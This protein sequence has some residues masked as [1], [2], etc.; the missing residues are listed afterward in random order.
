MNPTRR[1][2]IAILAAGT[3]T[4]LSGAL[5]GASPL[6]W[7]GSGLG[8]RASLTLVGLDPATERRVV[9]ACRDEISR[10]EAVFS[11]YRDDSALSHLN[12]EGHLAA[13]PHELVDVLTAT[14]RLHA[15]SNG[16]FDP[17]VQPLWQLLARTGG[18]P[19]PQAE[20]AAR[21]RIGWHRVRWSPDAID[22]GPGMALTLN[23]IAQGYATDR[24]VATLRRAGLQSA[25]V[26]VGEIAALGEREDG[27]PWRIGVA[28]HEDGRPEEVVSLAN[29]CAATSAPSGTLLDA[30]GLVGHILDPNGGAGREWRRVTVV[31]RSA[32]IADGLSTACSLLGAE[33][34][35]TLLRA[36]PGSRLI[37]IAEDGRRIDVTG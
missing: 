30:A 20:A 4:A 19:D 15:A 6:S 27:M 7:S 3:A 2:A 31:H 33:T 24:I 22:L 9:A 16:A 35:A 23:G 18:R 28:E 25:L 5:A 10:I 26:S 13:P 21:A 37:G 34:V 8:A 14:D 11:L 32:T 12:R 17:T 29:R 36:Y 1:R